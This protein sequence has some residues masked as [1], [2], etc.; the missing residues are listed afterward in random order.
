MTYSTRVNM[1]QLILSILDQIWN[2]GST[3][4]CSLMKFTPS[5]SRFQKMTQLWLNV[6]WNPLWRLPTNDASS[7]LALTNIVGAKMR[8][9]NKIFVQIAVGKCARFT[10]RFPCPGPARRRRTRRGGAC[11]ARALG[12]AFRWVGVRAH[13]REPRGRASRSS[14]SHGTLCICTLGACSRLCRF[15]MAACRTLCRY[16]NDGVHHQHPHPP[17]ASS[18]SPA[19]A[20]ARGRAKS[21]ARK[22][23]GTPCCR[24]CR[25]RR[26]RRPAAPFRRS[27]SA[28]R[29]APCSRRRPAPA[30]A[31]G[32]GAWRPRTRRGPWSSGWSSR[33]GPGPASRRRTAARRRTAGTRRR[34]RASAAWTR[35]DSCR[36]RCPRAAARWRCSTCRRRG[37][38]PACRLDT[39]G[40][41]ESR[42]PRR[43]RAR[44]TRAREEQVAELVQRDREHAVGQIEGLL[45]A[46]AV[47]DIDVDVE[48]ALVVPAKVAVL[49][50]PVVSRPAS[51]T[52]LSSS[53]MAMTMSL[54]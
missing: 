34:R 54:T 43:E 11:E 31:A 42:R 49:S 13:L 17:R 51:P 10:G 39:R 26:A 20:A 29:C 44:L 4:D 15:S 16:C 21:R 19:A 35:S 6:T 14:R 38:R 41:A 2:F 46:V 9:V 47:V 50:L 25:R 5:F 36:R 53:R 37:P 12:R 45:D 1:S 23:P 7:A 27:S 3:V 48:H 8:N 24:G 52:H 30:W 28:P 40:Q 32:T 33:A 22:T 18:G